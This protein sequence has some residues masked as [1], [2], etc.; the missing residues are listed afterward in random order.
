M[1]RDVVR[2]L[3]QRHEIDREHVEPEIKVFA[4]AAAPHL[5][6]QVAIG[7]GDH[8]HI[9]MARALLA[10]ALELALLQHAQKLAL[11]LERYLA[12]LVEE[13]RAAVGEL[14]PADAVAQRAFER[15]LGVAEEF[16]FEQLGRDRR[17]IDPDQR[18]VAAA[19]RLVD[20][21]R[22]QLLAGAGLAGDQH[23]RIGWRDQLDLAAASSGSRRFGR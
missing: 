2:A 17:A 21:A 16:A 3:A 6:L 1:Q 8:A 22:H 11:K 13:Q 20:R 9:D 5:R 19:A 18:P 7:R 12:D 15:A 14:E 23:R 4:E 10:D